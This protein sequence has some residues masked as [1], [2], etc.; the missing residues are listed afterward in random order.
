MIDA[1]LA[2]MQQS[3]LIQAIDTNYYGHTQT[4]FIPNVSRD[5]TIF[6]ASEIEDLDEVIASY[7]DKNG[8]QLTEFSHGDMP[9][10][11]VEHIG[12]EISYDLAH[13]REGIYS[14][15]SDDDRD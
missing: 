7:G 4:R 15:A 8:K 12:D 14:V 5:S 1:V 11:A 10:K 2:L 6:N 13:Y 3:K 9:Y